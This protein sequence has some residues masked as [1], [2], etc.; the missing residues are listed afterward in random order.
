VLY[1]TMARQRLGHPTAELDAGYVAA[2][3]LLPEVQ[4]PLRG[5]ARLHAAEPDRAL[6]L[7]QKVIDDRPRAVWAR[8]WTA[9][10]LRTRPNPD[11][12]R[13]EAVLRERSRSR[14]RQVAHFNLA[15]ILDS[16][17]AVVE[18][19]A[20]VRGRRGGRRRRRRREIADAIS[21]LLLADGSGPSC[22]RNCGGARG[23]RSSRRVRRTG[24]TRTTRA[25][26]TAD[27]ARD[28]VTGA[29]LP[30]AAAAAN[31]ENETYRADAAKAKSDPRLGQ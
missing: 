14:A 24:S 16:K 15:Q 10:V 28:P 6:E 5:L 20:R 26:G 7:L 9:Y 22:R 31:P 30:R 3:R 4:T 17:G 19:G 18:R 23:M 13:A 1:A 2:A 11:V 27:I 12:A 25:G 29:P 21:R 8:V